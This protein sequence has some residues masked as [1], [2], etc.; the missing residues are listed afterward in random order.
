MSE[1]A[2][3][4]V[5]SEAVLGEGASR[6]ARQTMLVAA[7]VVLIAA[8]AKVAVP[9]WP[10]PITM[11]T[12][13]VLTVGAAYG[14]GLGLATL[15]TYLAVGAAGVPVFAGETAGLSYMLGGTGGYLVGYAL[16]AGVLGWAAR[17]G[18]D[19]T[20][21][22]MAAALLAGNLAIYV[23]GLLWLNQMPYAEGWAWTVENGALPFLLGDALK[24]VLAAMV[25]PLAWRLTGRGR[26]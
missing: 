21:L 7:G 22:G 19:R 4:P 20:V 1:R 26:D 24:L 25:L 14:P 5:L 23:P 11:T 9:M 2:M 13:A 3:K 8:A 15:L 10:V 17:R 12:F 16:A 6:L 18:L